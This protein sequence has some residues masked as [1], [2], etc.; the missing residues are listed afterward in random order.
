MKIFLYVE[1]FQLSVVLESVNV[2][3]EIVMLFFHSIIAHSDLLAVKLAWLTVISAVEYITGDHV[4]LV[5]YSHHSTW[6]SHH[7]LSDLMAAEEFHSVV[8]VK[9]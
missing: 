7:P 1:D 9:F 5:V 3:F 6:I 8:I 2:E 4:Q